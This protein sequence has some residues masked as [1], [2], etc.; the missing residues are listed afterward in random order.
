MITVSTCPICS[1][2]NFIEYL[3]CKDYTTS[4][5]NFSLKKCSQCGFTITDP[6]P[7]EESIGNYYQSEKYISHT[8]GQKNFLDSIYI[9]ARRIAL[10]KKH[11]ILEENSALGRVLDMGCGTGEF[12]KEMKNHGWEVAGV[13]P[14]DGANKKAQET[15]QQKISKSIS[16]LTDSCFD[17]ITLWH[18]LEHLHDLNGTLKRLSELLK[19]SG[20]I[21]IAVPNLKSYD[22]QF[23]KSFWAAYDV[24]RHLWHFCEADMKRLLEKNGFKLM[25][26][27]PMKMDSFY[28]SLLSESYKNPN[29]PKLIALIK[30][31]AKGCISNIKARKNTNYSS[32]IYIAKR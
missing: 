8:G 15:T 11:K 31:F 3:N 27:L 21:F 19:A 20:T 5:E 18:V 29:Q 10:K 17:A 30:A 9:F 25:K 2:E 14:S 28:V 12:L 32:L 16:E 23:Y 22:A 24:P 6:K 26:I 4:G 13:E 7:D 1:G